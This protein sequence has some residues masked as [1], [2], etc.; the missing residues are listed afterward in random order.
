MAQ[1]AVSAQQQYPPPGVYGTSVAASTSSSSSYSSTNATAVAAAAAAGLAST[2]S[3]A[4][5]LLPRQTTSSNSTPIA[6]PPRPSPA[7]TRQSNYSPGQY[8]SE[9]CPICGRN[10]KGPKASTHKQQHIRRLHPED[11]IPKRGGK[12]RVLPEGQSPELSNAHK[13]LYTSLAHAA[14]SDSRPY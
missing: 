1:A 2:A 9:D 11:Y 13:S 8:K 14:S 5:E 3:Q 10:F 4:Q 12:K 6:K 7:N